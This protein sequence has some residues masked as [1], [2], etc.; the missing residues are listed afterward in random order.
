MWLERKKQAALRKSNKHKQIDRSKRGG[1][2][3]KGGRSPKKQK[4][5]NKKK[6]LDKVPLST[7]PSFPLPVRDGRGPAP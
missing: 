1:A 5:D 7:P 2:E 3:Q 6:P 4:F